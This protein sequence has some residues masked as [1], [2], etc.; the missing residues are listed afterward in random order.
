M[1]E[2]ARE[3]GSFWVF[4]VFNALYYDYYKILYLFTIYKGNYS[5][6][7]QWRTVDGI[8]VNVYGMRNKNQRYIGILKDIYPKIFTVIRDD[9]IYSYSYS[10]IIN[11]EVCLKFI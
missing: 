1:S 10:D 5:A 2:K 6:G 3:T 8:I 4:L 9:K 7:F 11:G